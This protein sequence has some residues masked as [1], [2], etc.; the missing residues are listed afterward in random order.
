MW[1]IVINFK[2]EFYLYSNFFLLKFVFFYCPINL[3][4]EFRRSRFELFDL[5]EIIDVDTNSNFFF[6][7]TV[8]FLVNFFL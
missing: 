3:F 7:D 2:I 4:D 5:Y 8:F 1:F 6:M